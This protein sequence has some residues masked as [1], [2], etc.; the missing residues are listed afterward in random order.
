MCTT[1]NCS[2][3]EGMS[4]VMKSILH[5]II[6]T[7]PNL[8]NR[9]VITLSPKLRF[10]AKALLK[11]AKD[12]RKPMVWASCKMGSSKWGS[13]VSEF[14]RN[15]F[16]M[17]QQGTWI[18]KFINLIADTQKTWWFLCCEWLNFLRHHWIF[19]QTSQWLWYRSKFWCQR[20]IRI[21]TS[22][23]STNSAMWHLASGPCWH[24]QN[25]S[26]WKCPFVGYDVVTCPKPG[27]SSGQSI[28]AG[29]VVDKGLYR[30][31]WW[32]MNTNDHSEKYR[33]HLGK[34]ETYCGQ[35]VLKQAKWPFECV[36]SVDSLCVFCTQDVSRSFYSWLME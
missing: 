11:A 34:N 4:L 3:L 8:L 22:I 26:L 24:I 27:K 12:P 7:L 28:R 20:S 15:G 9:N 5:S 6:S 23:D 2:A 31:L 29:H 25:L 21:F 14:L 36:D 18:I 35:R 17:F 30:R 1:K 16:N 32:P 19:S 10:V 13:P 33:I